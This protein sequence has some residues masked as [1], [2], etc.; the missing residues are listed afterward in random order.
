MADRALL[1]DAALAEALRHFR[2]R[3]LRVACS[4]HHLPTLDDWAYEESRRP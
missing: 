3:H 2:D 1:D 4:D